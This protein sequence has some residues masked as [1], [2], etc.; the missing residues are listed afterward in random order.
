MNGAD[1]ANQRRKHI[2][3]QRKANKRTWRPLFF[4]LLDMVL[5]LPKKFTS[6]FLGAVIQSVED[7]IPITGFS[8]RH[9]CVEDCPQDGQTS[10]T[11]CHRG[12]RIS[13]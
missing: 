3:T 10:Y 5:I 7:A 4:W 13:V 1:V 9:D 11:L 2:T 8:V 6:L 12:R